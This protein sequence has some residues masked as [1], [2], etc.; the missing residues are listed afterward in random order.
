MKRVGRVLKVALAALAVLAA[1]LVSSAQEHDKRKLV[2]LIDNHIFTHKPFKF[3][4]V[5]LRKSIR[6]MLEHVRPER[7]VV[8]A[9]GHDG[10]AQYPS[11]FFPAQ[12]ASPGFPLLQ[13]PTQDLL[14]IWREETTRTKTGMIVYVSTLRNDALQDSNPEYFRIFGNG[15]R[16]TVIDHNSAYADE[17]LLPGLQ[18]IID[19]YDPDGFFLDGDYWTAHESWNAASKAGFVKET[20]LPVPTDYPQASYPAFV[21]YTY[22]S[23]RRDYVGKLEG[24]FDRQKRPLNWS[25]NAAFTVRDPSPEPAN[26]GTVAVDLPFFALGE[27]YIESLFSQ[28]LK[29]GAEIVYPLFAQSE[30]AAPYQY[31]TKAQLKQEL[32]VAVVNRS[33]V[34][35]YLPL[36]YDGTIALDRIQP[37]IETYDEFENHIGTEAKPEQKLLAKIAIVNPNG[38]AIATRRFEELRKASL[39]LYARG[40]VHAITTETLAPS[41]GYSH[42]VFP[43][44]NH[45]ETPD[46]V[47]SLLREGKRVLW[48]VNER[49][50]DEKTKA[51]VT[52][53]RA[54]LSRSSVDCGGCEALKDA[55]G[56]EIW[57]VPAVDGAVLDRFSST[58][59]NAVTFPG[60]P[61]YVYALAYG[62]ATGHKQT[63]YLSSVAWGGYAFGR[64]TLFDTLDTTPSMNVRLKAPASCVQR[65]MGGDIKLPRGRDLTLR[66]FDTITKLECEL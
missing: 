34:S 64:H 27:A 43:R 52:R 28:R 58:I 16:A 61:D 15:V 26:Y 63:I 22:D 11:K 36:G 54:T 45:A 23:Y 56:G 60:K 48:A 13:A 17:V 30:G 47:P 1:P 49:Q 62:D 39:H 7:V 44:M 40:V 3:D 12:K 5:V 29:G 42:F 53:L 10:H 59:D 66:P 6:E 41:G 55:S 2:L 25:I 20:G 31:K 46:L 57:I 9:V 33:L 24:F 21:K 8:F 19:R 65:T 37:A 38:D 35:F 4:E 50:A 14:Q 51:V 32:A 18:E